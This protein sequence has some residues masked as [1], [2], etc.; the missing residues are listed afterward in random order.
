MRLSHS[1]LD[2]DE[3]GQAGMSS[4]HR[5]EG[6][7][8]LVP[9]E[10]MCLCRRENISIGPR[11]PRPLVCTHIHTDAIRQKDRFEV[12]LMCVSVF[13]GNLKGVYCSFVRIL[14][15]SPLSAQSHFINQWEGDTMCVCLCLS[16]VCLALGFMF[17]HL[18]SYGHNSEK[19]R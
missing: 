8:G 18:E 3:A 13:F 10:Q 16:K 9:G 14:S 7:R 5:S 2:C 6:R 12:S 11:K 4:G 17:N 15:R 19:P 1:S